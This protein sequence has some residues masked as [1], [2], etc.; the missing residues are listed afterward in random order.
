MQILMEK[1][2]L[3]IIDIDDAIA[4]G[5]VKLTKAVEDLIAEGGGGEDNDE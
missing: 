5:Y 2:A 3:V 1:S 4:N